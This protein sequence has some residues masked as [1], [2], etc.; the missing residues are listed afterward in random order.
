MTKPT[1]IRLPED[2]LSELDRRA[3][4]RGKDRATLCRSCFG[5]HW[6]GTR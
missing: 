2:V 6:T 3:E 4:A 1:T 5:L